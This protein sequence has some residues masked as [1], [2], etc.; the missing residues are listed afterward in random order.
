MKRCLVGILLFFG[1]STCLFAVELEIYT[2]DLPPLNMRN[3]K[4]DRAMGFSVDIVEELLERTSIR[5]VDGKIKVYPWSRAYKILRRSP[6][7]MLF[8]MTRTENRENLFKWVGPIA[9]RT[10]W[11]WKMKNRRDIVVHSLN[12]AKQYTIGGVYEFAMSKYLQGE[13]FKMDMNTNIDANWLKLFYNRIDLGTAL[14]LEAAYY[15]KK[16]G[17]KFSELE[18]LVKVDD[19]YSFY[20]ALSLQTAD[21]IVNKLQLALDQMKSDGSYEL[22]RKK[23]LE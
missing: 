4:T 19:R 2:E 21:D 23:H 20:I 7:V 1:L 17:R 15:M 12:D 18:R 14:E 16:H 9:P 6:N 8:S 3:E 5:P 13:G 11:L 10:V 22:I